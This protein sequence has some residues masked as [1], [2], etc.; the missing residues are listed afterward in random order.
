MKS[1]GWVKSSNGFIF[2]GTTER[3]LNLGGFFSALDIAVLTNRFFPL[4]YESLKESHH[5]KQSIHLS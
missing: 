1:V 3:R 2:S 5:F 4:L